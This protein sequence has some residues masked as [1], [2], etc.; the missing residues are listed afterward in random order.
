MFIPLYIVAALFVIYFGAFARARGTAVG[1]DRIEAVTE[2]VPPNDRFS[3][4]QQTGFWARLTN[5]NQISQ[6]AR[7]AHEDGYLHGQ[8]LEYLGF[9][10]IPRFLWHDKPIVQKGGWFAWRIGQAWIRADGRYSNAINMTVP[11]E[12]YLN[13]GWF[14]VVAGCALFGAFVALLWS[15][16]QFWA[17]GSTAFG[18]AF[19]YYLFWTS[20]SLA[21]DLQIAI[22]LLATYCIFVSAGLA[23]RILP[24]G[25]R[26][27]RPSISRWESVRR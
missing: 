23:V 17:V 13:Y 14:G 11:G 15:R 20:L 19:G 9:V 24:V 6:I 21:A 1:I 22:T 10:F 5:F 16:T 26:S 27:D 3:K 18:Q 7:I 25:S 4:Q 2:G 12:L 8:T